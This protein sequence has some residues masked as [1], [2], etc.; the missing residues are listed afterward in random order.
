MYV[1]VYSSA[2]RHT[3]FACLC[4]RI[5]LHFDT[6]VSLVCVFSVY[7]MGIPVIDY[8]QLDSSCDQVMEACETW[9]FFIL[10]NVFPPENFVAGIDMC[11]QLFTVSSF[12]KAACKS[13][14]RKLR[15]YFS[16]G[17]ENVEGLIDHYGSYNEG[18]A[19]HKEGWEF[20]RPGSNL[21]SSRACRLFSGVDNSWPSSFPKFQQFATQYYKEIL[22]VGTR[23]LTLIEKVSSIPIL[24]ACD[25]PT[26]TLRFLHYWPPPANMPESVGIGAHRDYGLITLLMVDDCGGL[27]ILD[28]DGKWMK[29]P[30]ISNSIIVNIGDMLMLWT[31]GRFKSNIHRVIHR[32]TKHRYSIPFFLEPNMQTVIKTQ[33]GESFGTCEEILTSF[34]IKSGLL[35]PEMLV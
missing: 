27:E 3:R 21:G 9:G 32:G 11:A 22:G 20:G 12:E 7:Y 17:D 30:V 10:T 8:T 24:A 33:T 34:Y 25:N 19:D 28:E 5:Q 16:V 6:L 31:N 18:G 26:T 23:V 4:V 2:F 14:G 35:K 1:C 29:V 15:G 13:G